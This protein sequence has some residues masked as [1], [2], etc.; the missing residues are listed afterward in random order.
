MPGICTS[1]FE[2]ETDAILEFH[3]R[4]ADVSHLRRSKTI[5]VPNF[6]KISQSTSAEI[7][8]LPL[9]FSRNKR[10]PSWKSTS[11]YHSEH[12]T[13]VSIW[14]YV[15]QPNFIWTGPSVTELWCHRFSKTAATAS[16]IY[17]RFPVWWSLALAKV[18]DYPDTNFR[19]HILVHGLD[20][21]TS[22][23]WKL[24]AAVLKFYIR[25][26][27]WCQISSKLDHMWLNSDVTSIFQT[28]GPCVGSK[29][30]V[31][32]FRFRD[33]SHVWR[34]ETIGMSNFAM[35]SQSTAEI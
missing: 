5:R 3:F 27:F 8:L 25:F 24:N 6:A 32:G 12:L 22:G 34:S 21:T 19:Q 9:P 20:I 14:F 18:K 7:L 23:F 16:K 17:F 15:G 30:S 10:L 35:I 13:I 26:P 29:I 33:D 2:N 28:G 4:F 1:G 11:T 31:S